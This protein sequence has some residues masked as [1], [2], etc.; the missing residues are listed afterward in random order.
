MFSR[1]SFLL[2]AAV[3]AAALAGTSAADFSVSVAFADGGEFAAAELAARVTACAAIGNTV[4]ESDKKIECVRFLIDTSAT[5]VEAADAETSA[6]CI[7]GG[8]QVPLN[9][10]EFECDGGQFD[11]TVVASGCLAIADHYAKFGTANTCAAADD[12]PETNGGYD[13]DC[14]SSAYCALKSSVT[15]FGS[16]C[17]AAGAAATCCGAD[18]KVNPTVFAG[19]TSMVGADHSFAALR[20]EMDH[21][22][23]LD[24]NVTY[25]ITSPTRLKIMVNV[26]YITNTSTVAYA[27]VN[28]TVCPSTYLIDF[29]DPIEYVPDGDLSGIR[30]GATG[31]HPEWLPLTHAL[32]GAT[33]YDLVG[34]PRSSC[35]NLDFVWNPS[36]TGADAF[37][38]PGPLTPS[39]TVNYAT[40]SLMDV[41]T[42]V[43]SLGEDAYQPVGK[44]WSSGLDAVMPGRF[45]YNTSSHLDIVNAYYQCKTY[46]DGTKVVGREVES[47]GTI[48]NGV[49]YPVETYSWEMKVCQVGY[50]GPECDSHNPGTS[51]GV[52]T[53]AKAC[54]RV[55]AAF[56]LSPQMI[57]TASVS[58]VDSNLVTKSFLHSVRGA[59]SDCEAGFERYVTVLQLMYFSFAHDIHESPEH[60]LNE[61]KLVFTGSQDNFVVLRALG[62]GSAE[63]TTVDDFLGWFASQSG[64][65]G[66]YRF[67]RTAFMIS[68]EQMVRQKFAVVSKCLFTGYDQ[69]TKTRSAPGAFGDTYGDTDG[70]VHVDFELVL[71]R[72]DMS[73]GLEQ[74]NTVN[75]RVLATKE[76]FEL[77]SEFELQQASMKATQYLYGSL[78]SAAADATLAGSMN[79][80]TSTRRPNDQVCSKHQLDAAFAASANLEP[81]AVGACMLKTPPGGSEVHP[82]KTIRW[83]IRGQPQEFSFTYG[84]RLGP[85][86]TWIDTTGT[87]MED[88]VYLF[89]GQPTRLSFG[90][91][92]SKVFWLVTKG[93]PNTEELNDE[94]TMAGRFGVGMFYYNTTVNA[95]ANVYEP[96][97]QVDD[98]IRSGLNT[99]GAGCSNTAGHMKSACNL[100]CFDLVRNLLSDEGGNEEVQVVVHHIS[101]AVVVDE[102]QG[103]TGNRFS[104]KL[105]LETAVARE[106]GGESSG[107]AALRVAEPH[108]TATDAVEA[109]AS[110]DAAAPALDAAPSNSTPLSSPPPSPPPSP[111]SPPPSPSPPPHQHRH[112]NLG[113]NGNAL[114]GSMG[115]VAILLIIVVIVIV[116]NS[117]GREKAAQA[118]MRRAG[119]NRESPP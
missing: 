32:S 13:G 11:D 22:V 50:F 89:D 83:R 14:Y 55:P 63:L 1:P 68:G 119:Y 73:A 71:K 3:L 26:P 99:L 110:S 21:V 27:G 95:Y 117:K 91:T 87:T 40:D 75:L 4:V 112:S 48:V 82:G 96:G 65:E 12:T 74:I 25:D 56:S 5:C 108:S 76:S 72:T 9:T 29:K 38:Y 104:R 64:G 103:A 98:T 58:P 28:Y 57:S 59:T 109:G 113:A 47:E 18:I 115:A 105:L 97:M 80:S 30:G 114:Y 34:K 20:T 8:V 90:D 62:S 84:C 15:V 52:S 106:T 43:F 101:V 39:S 60:D 44:M 10:L 67:S 93:T 7:I 35:A 100:V 2:A 69:T 94:F 24:I 49:E 116:A 31:I 102:G 17:P 19:G 88:G 66:V 78:K 81:N 6:Y 118:F 70:N 51:G 53:Y 54:K 107:A 46:S 77:S 85:D 79:A 41:N 111:P 33:N 45:W 36:S 23:D 37:D 42:T 92:H 61:P 16:Y 86:D